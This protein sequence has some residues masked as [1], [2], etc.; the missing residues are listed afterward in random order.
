MNSAS[1]MVI[2][3]L[4]K[5]STKDAT[6]CKQNVER[7]NSFEPL[8]IR[9]LRYMHQKIVVVLPF[10]KSRL[11]A[12][13]QFTR[14]VSCKSCGV[15]LQ[16]KNPS[17]TGYYK[18]PR[19]VRKDA[20]TI[21]DLKYL[22]FTQELQLKKHEIGLLDPDTDPDYKEPIPKRLVC[23]RCVDA[24]SHN[25]YNSSDF[26]IHSFNDIKGAL[27]HAA[28]V[29]HVVSLSDFP[30]SLDKTILAEKNNRN[31]LLLSK[32][33]QIT[34]KS[35]MLPHKGS[36]FFA[37][38]CRR[39][40]G[41][42]V[43]KVV[44]FSN[45]RN[46]NIPSVINALAK[47]CYL[48]GNPNVG[49]TSLINSLLHEKSTSFQ[50]QLDKRGNVIGPPKGHEQIQSTRRRAI[51]NEGG[52]SHIP[53]FTRTMQTYLIEDKVVN[54]LPG[55]TMD[56]TKVSDL[57]NYIEKET[58]DNIRKTSKFKIDKLIKQNYTSLTGSKTGKCLS[59]GGIFHLVPPNS[60][61]NQVVNY[62]PLP[63]HE[64]SNVE[65]AVSLSL[66]VLQSENHSLRQFFA[67]KKP[68]TDI[69][70][71]DRH[72]IPPFNGA[73]EIVLKDIGYFQVKP[74]GK[75]GFNG[76][77]ELW[78]PKGIRVCI[79]EPLSKL[80]SKSYEKYIESGDI[81]DVCPTDRPLISDTYIMN[82]TEEDTF[83]RMREM[84]I[85]RTS[86]DI[87]SRRL[88]QK[89]P[90]DIVGTLQSPPSNLYWYY[91]W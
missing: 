45:P 26:P 27:P 50:A 51:F 9:V 89:D 23:K 28:N 74:T 55:Y 70:M 4:G 72:V 61:I 22:M 90:N 1:N 16:S 24:I 38:F 7:C 63:E 66:E 49:K 64:F 73:I 3:M 18:P 58:L 40:I 30:L 19:A 65:K 60:T 6:N 78:V 59:F 43:K 20:G 21:E 53:S 5:V 68:F 87:L 79:R 85:N 37:E 17:V 80:I 57:A 69:K 11:Q 62:I 82:H 46:W 84:Y 36:A 29:Y 88:L 34:Y 81:A 33:D 15:E 48:L 10:M 54:D 32:A 56:P 31:Y 39:H 76:L 47:R 12:F 67:L 52:V 77:Y 42:H 8:L 41:V 86:K 75:Y 83:A 35:S 71:F 13:K 44:L 91:K 25:R 2:D 14:F